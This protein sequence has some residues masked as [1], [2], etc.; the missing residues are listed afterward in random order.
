MKVGIEIDFQRRDFSINTERLKLVDELGYDMVFSA[1]GTG[2]DA[3]TPLGYALGVTKRI[4]LGTHVIAGPARAPATS[5]MGYQ[6][7]RHLAPE[8]EIIA[9]IGSSTPGKVEGFLGVP[10]TA[11]HPRMRELVTIMRRCFAQESLEFHG[12]IYDI[13]YQPPGGEPRQPAVPFYLHPRDNPPQIMFGG[14]T[15]LMLKLAAE[16]AD[17]IMPNGSWSPGMSRVYRP[18][19]EPVLA[20][21]A[22][23]IKYE[24]FPIWAHVDVHVTDDVKAALWQFREYAARWSGGYSGIGG[25]ETHMRWRG[26][27]A[28]FERIRELY[29]AGHIKEAEAAVPDE[30]LDEC[31]LIGPI[32][33]IVE[34]WRSRW[35]GDGCNLIIRTDGWISAKPAGNEAYEPL[36]RAMRD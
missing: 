8:R 3:F 9:G 2:S 30:Y 11:A 6:T 34:R 14:G 28:A 29:Q 5:A 27:G 18:M 32:D 4:G 33:R 24:D 1:E 23:P 22:K 25:L 26:Y 12:K 36:I 31:W 16:I 19:L 17:G 13:P 10:W 20:K 7:L 21:R 15:E 35:V